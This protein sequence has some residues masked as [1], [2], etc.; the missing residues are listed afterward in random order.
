[1]VGGIYGENPLTLENSIVANNS[2]STGPDCVGVISGHYNLIKDITGCGFTADGTDII[3]SDPLLG[4]L[5]NN[6]GPTVSLRPTSNSPV[7]DKIPSANCL[8]S[9]INGLDQR[10][11]ARN[12]DGD[13]SASSNECD[14]G[15]VEWT[16]DTPVS[17][18][19]SVGLTAPYTVTLSW[20]DGGSNERYDL[21]RSLTPYGGHGLWSA[22]V[23]PPFGFAHDQSMTP[24]FYTVRAVGR[25]SST[26]DSNEVGLF[27]FALTAGE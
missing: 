9:P 19:V 23:A 20:S 22:D 4:P 7:I 2:A 26:A 12:F 21:Y 17:T 3:G 24:Y 6:G 11:V 5:Q 25:D 14:M 8:A 27:R 15:A 16:V 18:S 13:L 1:M 10:G